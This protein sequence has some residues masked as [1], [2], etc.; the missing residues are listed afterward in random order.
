MGVGCLGIWVS[1]GGVEAVADDGWARVGG[2]TDWTA[3][4]RGG[5]DRNQPL[6]ILGK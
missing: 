4:K 5:I 3:F 6:S 1:G 2:V